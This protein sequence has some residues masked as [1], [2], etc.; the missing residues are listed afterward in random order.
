MAAWSQHSTAT[1][2]GAQ[3]SRFLILQHR[4]S[5]SVLPCQNANAA[6][7]EHRQSADERGNNKRQATTGHPMWPHARRISTAVDLCV[8]VTRQREQRVFVIYIYNYHKSNGLLYTCDLPNVNPK[9][10]AHTYT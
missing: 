4:L 9:Y 1:V 8:C 2:H 10:K 3:I 5:R 7:G 6:T